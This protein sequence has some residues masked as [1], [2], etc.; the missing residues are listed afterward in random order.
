[1]DT[2]K[3]DSE[4]NEEDL[5]EAPKPASRYPVPSLL[6]NRYDQSGDA[7]ADESDDDDDDDDEDDYGGPSATSRSV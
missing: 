7:E 3:E 5:E 4:E 1:M 6:L 2:L